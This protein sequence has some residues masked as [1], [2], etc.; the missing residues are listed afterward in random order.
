[1]QEGMGKIVDVNMK[2]W[3]LGV[4]FSNWSDV[5][6]KLNVEIP[7]CFVES[8]KVTRKLYEVCAV[9]NAARRKRFCPEQLQN[10]GSPMF[11]YRREDRAILRWFGPERFNFEGTEED[12]YCLGSQGH[13][14]GLDEPAVGGYKFYVG[15]TNDKTR[16]HKEHKEAIE[17]GGDRGSGFIRSMGNHGYHGEADRFGGWKLDARQ[18]KDNEA[19]VV[20]EAK[21]STLVEDQT[22]EEFCCKHGLHHVRGGVYVF[23]AQILKDVLQVKWRQFKGL[24]MLCGSHGHK[25][26]TCP[27]PDL[28]LLTSR[29]QRVARVLFRYKRDDPAVCTSRTMSLIEEDDRSNDGDAPIERIYHCARK[30]MQILSDQS[31]PARILH[32][33]VENPE[34]D[35]VNV[36]SEDQVDRFLKRTGYATELGLREKQREAIKHVLDP[37]R[38]DIT[39]AVPTAYGKTTVFVAAAIH[40]VLCGNGKAVVWLPF[41]ALMSEIAETFAALADRDL[42]VREELREEFGSEHE[43]QEMRG[44]LGY[45]VQRARVV[46]NDTYCEVEETRTPYGGTFYVRDHDTQLPRRIT[47]TVWRGVQSDGFMREHQNSDTFKTAD[48]ILATPD[49][50]TWPDAKNGYCDSF[51]STFRDVLHNI[52]LL[53]V[54]EAHQFSEVFGANIREVIKRMRVLH[55]ARWIQHQ[56]AGIGKRGPAQCYLRFRTLLSSATLAEPGQFTR[57]LLGNNDQNTEIVQL[58]QATVYSSKPLEDAYVQLDEVE[59]FG[60]VEENDMDAPPSQRVLQEMCDNMKERADQRQQRLALFLDGEIK[61]NALKNMLAPSVIHDGIRRCLIFVDSKFMANMLTVNLYGV[62]QQWRA[63]GKELY[64]TPYHGDCA[65][66]HRRVYE[67]L[68][69]KWVPTGDKHSLHVIVATSALE[70][71]VNIA[72]CDLVFVLD[73]R[74]CSCSS[75][76]QRI[77]RGGRHVGRPALVVIGISENESQRQGERHNEDEEADENDAEADENDKDVENDPG[78]LLLDPQKYLAEVQAQSGLAKSAAIPLYGDLQLI[79]DASLLRLDI[80]SLPYNTVQRANERELVAEIRRKIP[81]LSDDE[82]CLPMRGVSSNTVSVL[83][84]D[85]EG[86]LIVARGGARIEIAKVDAIKCFDHYHPEAQCRDP[87]GRTVFAGF[88]YELRRNNHSDTSW[89]KRLSAVRVALMHDKHRTPVFNDRN[90]RSMTSSTWVEDVSFEA[91]E[92]ANAASRRGVVTIG[93][94]TISREWT[95]YS[96]SCSNG[97]RTTKTSTEVKRYSD[98]YRQRDDMVTFFTPAVERASGW[99]CNFSLPKEHIDERMVRDGCLTLGAALEFSAAESLNCSTQ[100]INV[101]I[102]KNQV[103]QDA[104]AVQL[105][106]IV[107]E[108]AHTGL[109][110]EVTEHLR[111]WI[112]ASVLSEDLFER[113]KFHL[114]R[115]MRELMNG[116][117]L[118]NAVNVAAICLTELRRVLEPVFT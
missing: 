37:V 38:P 76:T 77:G 105:Q 33:Y 54:D 63:A 50:W 95:G 87:H 72:G 68:F 30:F 8:G 49:K 17:N 39:L 112:S 2:R 25:A 4:E 40:E 114:S 71:G 12:N 113:K 84:C 51:V 103:A 53:V 19:M 116:G 117:R 118:A 32:T 115:E 99:T 3:P 36:V 65:T 20:T 1:M 11:R 62:Q 90:A 10:I 56:T 82:I 100:H 107:Y 91:M 67:G 88:G 15:T 29:T 24:C 81:V 70:A 16:R 34:P 48:I 85:K 74:K 96:I 111:E 73:A 64:V 41:N 83:L 59:P 31:S 60:D 75:L 44:L 7:E 79:R 69:R 23:S 92:N 66:H 98:Y 22:T 6:A 89:L 97:K 101:R 109:A 35:E 80:H 9:L 61:I 14:D 43:G 21:V 93:V 78:L 106:L 94:V 108:T 102:K 86:Q 42:D 55:E 18:G 27:A 46:R 26:K 110:R 104:A 57:Q 58:R 5:C 28:E 47:W 45:V 13:A 52:G